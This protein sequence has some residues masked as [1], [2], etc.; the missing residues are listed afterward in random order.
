MQK[1][2]KEEKN[3]HLIA[4]HLTKRKVSGGGAGEGTK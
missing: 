3:K 1:G 2:H 4:I